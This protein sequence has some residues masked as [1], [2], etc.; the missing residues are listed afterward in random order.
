MED[1]HKDWK[2][3]EDGKTWIPKDQ[4]G[5][6]QVRLTAPSSVIVRHA[7]P[8]EGCTFVGKGENMKL[9]RQSLV[10]HYDEDHDDILR[11]ARDAH[12]AIA[13]KMVKCP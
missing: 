11:K 7:C 3:S 4:R 13:K 10:S 9:A 5:S 6:S 2:L 1:Y 12:A 8:E